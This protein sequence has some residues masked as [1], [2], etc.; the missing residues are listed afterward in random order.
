[1]T[2]YPSG[3][4]DFISVC[5]RGSM[6]DFIGVKENSQRDSKVGFCM[7][8]RLYYPTLLMFLRVF[9]VAIC[10]YILKKNVLAT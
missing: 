4:V 8:A 10:I 6:L 9:I 5:N 2:R 1:M 3:T 7:H